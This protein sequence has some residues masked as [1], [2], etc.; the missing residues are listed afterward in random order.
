ML[1]F[2]N[3]VLTSLKG[4]A[5]KEYPYEC[6]GLL[7]GEYI[8]T[9]IRVNHCVS[10]SNVANENKRKNFEIDPKVRF[11]V[12]RTLEGTSGLSIV[13][14]YHSHPDE[15]ALPSKQ[16]LEMVFEPDLAWIILSVVKGSV[17]DIAAFLYNIKQQAFERIQIKTS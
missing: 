4:F 13:G 8:S 15:P 3:K 16:D 7:V 5:E 1:I 6:C 11:E 12:M 17:I 9:D 2:S 10:S 14:H